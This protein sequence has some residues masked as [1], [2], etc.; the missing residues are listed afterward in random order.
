MAF[1]GCPLTSVHIPQNVTYLSDAFCNC[2]SLASFTGKFTTTDGKMLINDGKLEGIA[3]Y[4]MTKCIVPEGVKR[5]ASR[6]FY[7]TKI[8]EIVFPESLELIADFWMTFSGCRAKTITVK[9]LTPPKGIEGMFSTYL[10]T[11]YVPAESV[12]TYKTAEHWSAYADKIKA[13]Q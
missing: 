9:A 10:E 6:V 4:G 5:I 8:E 2:S 13:I 1:M 7:F 11:I 12:E 3:P